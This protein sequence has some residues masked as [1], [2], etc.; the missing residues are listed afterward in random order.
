M[1]HYFHHHL[2][3]GIIGSCVLLRRSLLDKIGLLDERIQASDWDMYLTIRRRE[4]ECG[5][6]RRCMMV[7][8]VYV[9]HFIRATV[10]GKPAQFSCLH[11]RISL[12]EKWDFEIKKQ[13]WFDPREIEPS[14]GDASPSWQKRLRRLGQKASHKVSGLFHQNLGSLSSISAPE[15]VLS[16]YRKKFSELANMS[17]S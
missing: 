6:V 17:G 5:D 14:K 13:L 15:K 12:D 9:H 16:L 7:G 10:K 11:P 4:K 8:G 2:Y 3:E 1:Y